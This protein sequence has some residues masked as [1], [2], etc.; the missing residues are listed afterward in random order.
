M[1]YWSDPNVPHRGWECVDVIDLADYC[2]NDDEIRYQQCQMCSNEKIRF[3]H[4]MTHPDFQGELHVGC[5][6][7]EK[8][9]EDYVNPRNI[10]TYII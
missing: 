1:N 2:E 6:C 5:V 10:E 4:V 9:S 3:V 7:A 8:M